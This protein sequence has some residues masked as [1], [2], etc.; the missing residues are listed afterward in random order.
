[1]L[2]PTRSRRRAATIA[3]R[4]FYGGL[5]GCEEG[6]SSKTWI[7]WNFWGHQIVTHWAGNDVRSRG[8]DVT[9]ATGALRP[10]LECPLAYRPVPRLRLQAWRQA[11]A[12]AAHETVRVSRPGRTRSNPPAHPSFA[13]AQY[14]GLKIFNS[15]DHDMVPVPHFGCCM[16]VDDFQALA[17]KL[18]AANVKF[19]VEPH[20]RFVG[21]PGEQWTMF[22]ED[23]SGNNLEFK[24]MAIPANL[25]AKYYVDE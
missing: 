14:K 16:T 19:I 4:Q 13:V 12:V 10:R 8:V 22:F 7:D 23:P 15:V 2:P 21:K 20:L 24:A 18:K 9:A 1:M 3:A 11:P 5:L 6:R 25:F 17:A